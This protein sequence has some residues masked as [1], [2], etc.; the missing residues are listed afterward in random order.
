MSLSKPCV[1]HTISRTMV[2]IGTIRSNF[3]HFARKINEKVTGEARY[4]PQV[5]MSSLRLLSEYITALMPKLN[6]NW[7]VSYVK[8][9]GR[10]KAVVLSTFEVR[11]VSI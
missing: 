8:V 11:N 7:F 3:L 10:G 1:Y 2:K 6:S 5:F 9:G 4:D